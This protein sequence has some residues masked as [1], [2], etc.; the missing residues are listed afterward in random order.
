M[1]APRWATTLQTSADSQKPSSR[2]RADV[3]QSRLR[4]T[5]RSRSPQRASSKLIV[6]RVARGIG[7]EEEVVS[8]ICLLRIS[9]RKVSPLRYS[10]SLEKF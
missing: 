2:N 7:Q 4:S 1:H 3:A 5:T 6:S 9:L 8:G 10:L